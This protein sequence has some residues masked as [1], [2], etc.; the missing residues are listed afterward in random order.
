L[1]E[2]SRFA[3]SNGTRRDVRGKSHFFA[4]F[5]RRIAIPSAARC[6]I[7]AL[8]CDTGPGGRFNAKPG[9][10]IMEFTDK[11]HLSASDLIAYFTLIFAI[12]LAVSLVLAGAVLLLAGQPL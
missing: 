1:I 12:G 8:Q 7:R 9:A 2:Y 10:I 11:P 6:P 4:T 3:R 5:D